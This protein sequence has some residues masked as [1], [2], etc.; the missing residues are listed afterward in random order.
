MSIYSVF[1]RSLLDTTRD[2]YD[3]II[4]LFVFGGY[5]RAMVYF[6]RKVGI[7]IL[8]VFRKVLAFERVY[9]MLLYRKKMSQSS[10]ISNLT[11]TDEAFFHSRNKSLPIFF[12]LLER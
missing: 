12:I 2:F 10:V 9:F 3:M 4:V 7:W 11:R 5:R 1:G 8:S 6:L